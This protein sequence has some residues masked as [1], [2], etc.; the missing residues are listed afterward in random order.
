MRLSGKLRLI[1]AAAVL[2]FVSGCQKSGP[3]EAPQPKI[4]VEVSKVSL[5]DLAESIDSVGDIKAQEE[6]LIYPKVSGKIIEKLKEDGSY[7]RKGEPLCYIDRDEVGL[8]FEKAP[9][10]S[11]LSGFVGRF[12]PDIGANVTTQT[13]VALVVS[14]D[15]VKIELAVTEKYLPRVSLGQRAKVRVDAWPQEEFTGELTRISPVLDLSTRSAPVEITVDNPEGRLQSGMFARVE[16]IL[17]ERKDVPVILKEAVMGREPDTY[18]YVIQNGRAVLRKVSLGVRQGPYYEVRQGLQEGEEVVVM[19]QQR[20][21][22]G[23]AVSV[24]E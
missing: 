19:G 24:G 10:E 4:P 15:K 13:A 20:L 16:L 14:M 7:V 17:E 1:V 22:D 6:A 9:V 2:L 11:T 3:G 12:Y 18:I 5:Q 8:K 23:A 21:F